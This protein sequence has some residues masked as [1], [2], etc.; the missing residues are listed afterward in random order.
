MS[1][2]FDSITRQWRM[3]TTL[4]IVVCAGP[5]RHLVGYSEHLVSPLKCRRAAR[6][7]A[8]SPTTGCIAIMQCSR[9]A[10]AALSCWLRVSVGRLD[11]ASIFSE[12]NREEPRAHVCDCLRESK[13]DLFSSRIQL[14]R[15]R[16]SPSTSDDYRLKGAGRGGIGE[17]TKNTITQSCGSPVL[18]IMMY[19]NSR[20]GMAQ[21][22]CRPKARMV[23]L[24]TPT[25]PAI[26]RTAARPSTVH[27]FHSKRVN[28]TWLELHSQ[29]CLQRRAAVDSSSSQGRRRSTTV[30]CLS[31]DCVRSGK[32]IGALAAQAPLVRFLPA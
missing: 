19:L 1:D 3:E 2:L 10:T 28:A 8:F 25:A 12:N 31:V 22:Q 27:D 32:E 17:N 26:D 5:V 16:K 21:Q 13:S 29:Q 11:N 18:P 14:Q 30:G 9:N 24:P 4:L 15:P 23:L 6:V 7:F 20:V